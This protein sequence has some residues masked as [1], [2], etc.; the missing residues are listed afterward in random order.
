MVHISPE[1]KDLIPIFMASLAKYLQKLNK[2][3]E[4]QDIETI[5]RIGHKMMGTGGSYGLQV[6]SEIG[7]DLE[8][9]AIE[10]NQELIRQKI[11]EFAIYL[12]RVETV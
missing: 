6:I 5:E 7:V 4:D 9:A 8:N 10:K 11:E 2:A 3:L 1:I 12:E